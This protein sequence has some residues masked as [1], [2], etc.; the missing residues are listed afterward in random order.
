MHAELPGNGA[1][2]PLLDV[3]DSLSSGGSGRE[4]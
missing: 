1:D 2:L 3:M 4:P